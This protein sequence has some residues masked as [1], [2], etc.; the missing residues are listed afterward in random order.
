MFAEVGRLLSRFAQ[1]EN[2]VK[3]AP[4][5]Y[6][7]VESIVR[8]LPQSRCHIL[9]TIVDISPCVKVRLRQTVESPGQLHQEITIKHRFGNARYRQAHEYTLPC[10]LVVYDALYAGIRRLSVPWKV[11]ERTRDIY[12]DGSFSWQID[13]YPGTENK[14]V[15]LE[16]P[17]SGSIQMYMIQKGL[18]PDTDTT[19]LSRT[20]LLAGGV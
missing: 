7:K 9:D 18:T 5:A 17:D 2:E 13:T 1:L 4:S 14:V 10:A 19:L 15:E 20:A 11:T 6:S 3:I 16:G 12:A 8:E